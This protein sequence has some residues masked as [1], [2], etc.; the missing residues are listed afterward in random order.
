[1]LQL[2]YDLSSR[3]FAVH[4]STPERKET[5]YVTLWNL[6]QAGYVP[7]EAIARAILN[8]GKFIR[9]YK[10]YD[11]DDVAEAHAKLQP[12]WCAA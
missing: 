5:R 6:A 1:M 9:V 10:W 2:N 4:V 8:P 3:L 11:P 12:S 7:D